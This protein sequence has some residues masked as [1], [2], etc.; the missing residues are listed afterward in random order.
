M[1]PHALSTIGGVKIILSCLVFVSSLLMACDAYF[2]RHGCEQS[3]AILCANHPCDKTAGQL[4]E[5]EVTTSKVFLSS[6]VPFTCLQNWSIQPSQIRLALLSRKAGRFGLCAS[7]S[8]Q[9]LVSNQSCRNHLCCPLMIHV[10]LNLLLRRHSVVFSIRSNTWTDENAPYEARET[11]EVLRATRWAVYD[12][13]CNT[14]I[15]FFFWLGD[16]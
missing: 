3:S 4:I 13:R 2:S 8:C 10:M 6:F 11:Y 7:F 5:N 14:I 1:I 16:P 9:I 15:V 12:C